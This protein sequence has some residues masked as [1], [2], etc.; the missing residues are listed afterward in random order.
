MI[1]VQ[2]TSRPCHRYNV[3]TATLKQQQQ[4]QQQR[5]QQQQQHQQE[6]LHLREC[7]VPVHDNVP[8]LVFPWSTNTALVHHPPMTSHQDIQLHAATICRRMNHP[9]QLK[10][11]NTRFRYTSTTDAR[12]CTA[13]VTPIHRRGQHFFSFISYLPYAMFTLGVLLCC[14]VPTL[15]MIHAQ[16][17]TNDSTNN[18]VSN[19]TNIERAILI[20]LYEATDGDQWFYQTNWLD[21][22]TPICSWYGVTCYDGQ[23]QVSTELSIGVVELDLSNNN[24][25]RA[26]PAQLYGLPY[27]Q[28]LILKQNPITDASLEG[29]QRAAVMASLS[30]LLTLDLS[31]CLLTDISGIRHAPSTLQ[32]LQ[33]ANNQIRTTFD[34]AGFT[35]LLSLQIMD[36]TFN[37]IRGPIPTFIGEM[38]ALREYVQGVIEAVLDIDMM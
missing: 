4:Q 9:I 7:S 29:F 30:P 33:L 23:G 10:G 34:D 38:Q 15:R 13:P 28:S 8:E 5:Q 14:Y 31:H 22:S 27:L 35:E 20:A 36:L 24:L 19:T 18:S 32:V 17:T 37:Q 1:V 25:V 12:C 6:Q 26:L 21:E 11:M 3:T 16:N 2:C